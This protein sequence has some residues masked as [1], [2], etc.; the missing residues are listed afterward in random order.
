VDSEWALL[1]RVACL[2][3]RRVPVGAFATCRIARAR[4]QAASTQLLGEQTQRLIGGV[5]AGRDSAPL[6]DASDLAKKRSATRRTDDQIAV[7]W[8][9]KPRSGTCSSGLRTGNRAESGRRRQ[10]GQAWRPGSGSGGVADWAVARLRAA[11]FQEGH[12][13]EPKGVNLG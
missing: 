5:V 2:G 10:Q 3:H 13:V 11:S 12:D 7:V 8:K 6:G 4:E 1:H 9:R